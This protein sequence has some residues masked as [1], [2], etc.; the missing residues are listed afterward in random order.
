MTRWR[1]LG[2]AY[3]AS[4]AA[5]TAIAFSDADQDH[6]PAEIAAAVLGLPLV[7]PALPAIYVAGGLAWH[8]PMWLVTLTFTSSM[9]AV[10]IANAEVLRAVASGRSR[11]RKGSSPA[12]DRPGRAASSPHRPG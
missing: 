10:A 12:P 4:V 1:I 9:T 8:G 6:W 3:V 7:V 11:T 2:M 5:L